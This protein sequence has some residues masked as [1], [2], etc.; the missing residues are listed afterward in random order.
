MSDHVPG[1][2]SSKTEALLAPVSSQK[3]PA[4][5]ALH[6]V[7]PLAAM[8]V[9]GGHASHAV[10]PTSVWNEPDSHRRQLTACW[11]PTSG[12]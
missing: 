1:R 6:A 7:R 10:A 9:P 3:P 8:N 5:H 2:Q 11:L 4:S 12:L